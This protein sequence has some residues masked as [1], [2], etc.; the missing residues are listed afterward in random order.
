MIDIS[1]KIK[2]IVGP[3]LDENKDLTGRL[4]A[5]LAKIEYL[6]EAL[7]KQGQLKA[8]NY[9]KYLQVKNNLEYYKSE[10]A[11]H[12]EKIA[13][14]DALIG[15]QHD[16]IAELKRVEPKDENKIIKSNILLAL[17]SSLEASEGKPVGMRALLKVNGYL[18]NQSVKNLDLAVKELDEEGL[19][20]T[21][22]Y[23]DDRYTTFSM[24]N[25]ENNLEKDIDLLIGTIRQ[26]G[27]KHVS[28]SW[29]IK[30]Q[31]L[32]SKWD[33]EHAGRIISLTEERNLARVVQV[34]GS[35]T[36]YFIAVG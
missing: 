11:E 15:K 5:A 16:E 36:C 18:L 30:R 31:P 1:E 14:Q 34:G 19:I 4:N 17:E 8:E 21:H 32:I 24:A 7:S 3:V 23:W 22:N 2:D 13:V 35:G 9:S 29:I 12:L 27:V 26:G 25:T 6:D 20:Y 33:W 28:W 10:I